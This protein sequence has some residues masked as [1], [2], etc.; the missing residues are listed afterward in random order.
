MDRDSTTTQD[1]TV[2][3]VPGPADGTGSLDTTGLQ[4]TFEALRDLLGTGDPHWTGAELDL[5]I[6]VD[7]G[8]GFKLLA[9]ADARDDSTHKPEIVIKHRSASR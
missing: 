2:T 4:S 9:V 5:D 3:F 6:A 8:A 1:M 7:A